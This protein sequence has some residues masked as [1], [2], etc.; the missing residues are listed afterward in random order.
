MLN[1]G[2]KEKGENEM[3]KGLDYQ[4]E[5]DAFPIEGDELVDDSRMEIEDKLNDEEGLFDE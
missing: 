2:L 5:R 4:R 3:K 1:L